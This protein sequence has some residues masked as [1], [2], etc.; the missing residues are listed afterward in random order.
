M[1]SEST[2]I[3]VNDTKECHRYACNILD[4]SVRMCQKWHLMPPLIIAYCRKRPLDLREKPAIMSIEVVGGFKS[5]EH[6]VEC[7]KKAAGEVFNSGFI[8]T[9]VTLISECSLRFANSDIPHKDSVVIATL[10]VTK[11]SCFTSRDLIME[12][13]CKTIGGVDPEISTAEGEVDKLDDDNTSSILCRFFAQFATLL[14]DE[15]SKP[16]ERYKPSIN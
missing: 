16:T 14:D 2:S 11:H 8:P 10:A 7:M 3:I 1:R 9:V 6:K 5:D 4:E 15:E 12:N 13:D